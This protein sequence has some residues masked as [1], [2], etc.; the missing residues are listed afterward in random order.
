MVPSI[1]REGWLFAAH[2]SAEHFQRFWTAWLTSAN[3]SSAG[4]W[5]W[6]ASIVMETGDC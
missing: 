1:A 5:S 2:A 4:G 3:M 6:C